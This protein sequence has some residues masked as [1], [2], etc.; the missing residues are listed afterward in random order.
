MIGFF[1]LINLFSGLDSI[2]F[3][4][5]SIPFLLMLFWHFAL[6]ERRAHRADGK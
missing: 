2:W 3:Q 6:T 1:F 4:W 5:P